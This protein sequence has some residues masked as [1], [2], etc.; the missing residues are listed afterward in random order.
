MAA[1]DNGDGRLSVSVVAEGGA[2]LKGSIE[3]YLFEL[4][5]KR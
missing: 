1:A 2:D 3:L 5:I 4:T